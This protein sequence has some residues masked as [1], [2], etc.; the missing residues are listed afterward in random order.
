MIP[1]MK[2]SAEKAAISSTRQSTNPQILC[3]PHRIKFKLGISSTRPSTSGDT[4]KMAAP[5]ARLTGV[6]VLLLS[7][8]VTSVR[9]REIDFLKRMEA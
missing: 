9:R 3:H 2:K 5:R 8:R 1:S 4:D 7:S 6:S